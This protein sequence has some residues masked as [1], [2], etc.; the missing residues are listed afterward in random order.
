MLFFCNFFFFYN[1]IG[2]VLCMCANIWKCLYIRK[3]MIFA[4]LSVGIKKF[5]EIV[6][7]FD[8]LCCLDQSRV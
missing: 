6:V 8:L 3:S 2:T 5:T 7:G 1:L 4:L